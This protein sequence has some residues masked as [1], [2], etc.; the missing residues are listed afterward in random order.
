MSWHWEDFD[1][2]DQDQIVIPSSGTASIEIHNPLTGTIW[3]MRHVTLQVEKGTAQGGAV[4]TKGGVIICSS[5]V[6]STSLSGAFA[7]CLTAAGPPYEY[8]NPAESIF[9]TA[10]GCQPNVRYTVRWS[11]RLGVMY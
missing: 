6:L 2:N 7:S 9:V 10:Y 1:R 3:E 8:L 4:M 5:S 11:Y